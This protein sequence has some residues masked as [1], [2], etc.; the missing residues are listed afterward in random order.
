MKWKLTGRYLVSII[1]IVIVVIIVN[2]VLLIIFVLHQPS[3][4]FEG[5][6]GTSAQ[7]FTREFSAYLRMEGGSP[8]I[9]DEGK[10]ALADYGAWVQ[11][12]DPNGNVVASHLAPETAVAHYTPIDL[13]HKY[14]YMDDEFNT[15]FISPF[16][17][18]SYLIGVPFSQ[19]RRFF[20]MLDPDSLLQPASRALL[21][22]IVIDII[23]AAVIGLL[24][25]TLL[26]RP[27]HAIIERIAQLRRRDFRPSPPR[28]TGIYAS[29]FHNLNDVS[30]T[31]RQHEQERLQLERLR[32]EWIGNLSH[33]LKTPL[34][35]IQGYAE[36]L[37]G[38]E[39][40]AAE[41]ADYAGVI[42]RQ[43]I[44]MKDLLED[45]NL[46]MRLRSQN[47]PLQLEDTRLEA[48]TRELVID[49]LNDPQFQERDIAFVGEAPELLLP[50]DRHLMK[51]ALLNLV[52][53]A[54][55]HSGEQ[56]SVTVAVSQ[57]KL[58]IA[59]DGRGIPETE[60]ERVFERY[61]RGSHTAATR[62]TG[63]GM[64]IARDIVVAHGMTVTLESEVGRGTTVTVRWAGSTLRP[65]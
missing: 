46:T 26:S 59:D 7:T 41:R 29:V 16:E 47:L 30:E 9:T 12:L 61:Y 32:N 43:S 39:V 50:L 35:S 14:K 49:V 23:I 28:R 21:A 53:N 18:Y 1:C 45:L 13:V 31:L 56:A 4:G 25:S 51:R 55:I 42:E 5:I 62:G 22:V 38:D 54:L 33:D 52:H 64:A 57:T 20:I 19:E 8:V 48:F 44:Y 60:R 34:A 63:L 10:Q 3:S 58:V 27:V 24:F 2:T 17:E 40:S 37:N 11:I 6:Q 65:G 15:Y 36:L